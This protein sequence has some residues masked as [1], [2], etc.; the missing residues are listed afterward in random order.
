M[1]LAAEPGA[2]AI[3]RLYKGTLRKLFG[4]ITISN[5]ICFAPDHSS[6][7]FTDTV[8]RQIMRVPLDRNGWPAGTAQVFIDMKVD[9]LN[10]DG[11][12]VD[13][14]GRLWI[15]QWGAGRVACYDKTGQFRQAIDLPARNISCPAFGG[16]DYTSLFATSALQDIPEDVR[17]DAPEQGMTFAVDAVARGLPEP[18]V[19]L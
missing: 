18:Q 1:G 16:P 17:R 3:Y 19:L 7:Y 6:A 10:P 8:T 15:A 4:Q 9:N 11:A 12:V 5:A 2:G 14:D 13:A